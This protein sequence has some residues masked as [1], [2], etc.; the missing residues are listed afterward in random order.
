MCSILG[1]LSFIEPN[2]ADLAPKSF[3]LI[4]TDRDNQRVWIEAVGLQVSSE[5]SSLLDRDQ[6]KTWSGAHFFPEPCRGGGGFAA[7]GAPFDA[8]AAVAAV[9]T[10]CRVAALPRG[11]AVGAAA[12]P[13]RVAAALPGGAAAGAAAG[14][15]PLPAAAGMTALKGAAAPPLTAPATG[16]RPFPF[17]RGAAAGPAMGSCLPFC[18]A[19]ACAATPCMPPRGAVLSVLPPRRRQVSAM[20]TTN[21]TPAIPMPAYSRPLLWTALPPPGAQ[22]GAGGGGGEGG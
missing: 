2:S 14:A 10:P 8:V 19:A 20:P 5:S 7:G 6:R 11:A 15:A 22:G 9:A 18:A 21:T 13:G 4:E 12:L 17:G 3:F 16:A 1:Q